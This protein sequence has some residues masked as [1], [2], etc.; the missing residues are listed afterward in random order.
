VEFRDWRGDIIVVMAGLIAAIHVFTWR[1]K[2]VDGR[3]KGTAV[4]FD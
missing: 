4:R 1:A 2:D 3:H